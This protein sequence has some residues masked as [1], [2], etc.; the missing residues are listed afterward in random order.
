MSTDARMTMGERTDHLVLNMTTAA[1]G[2]PATISFEGKA[3]THTH[4]PRPWSL[5]MVLSVSAALLVA[6]YA[7]GFGLYTWMDP[8]ALA[9]DGTFNSFALLFVLSLAIERVLQPFVPFLGPDSQRAKRWRAMVRGETNMTMQAL[10]AVT[11]AGSQTVDVSEA[12]AS[13]PVTW[14]ARRRGEA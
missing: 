6:M 10:N 4:R 9:V 14:A 13:T 12:A 1:A 7:I 11:T 8:T 3:G 2:Q 5:T